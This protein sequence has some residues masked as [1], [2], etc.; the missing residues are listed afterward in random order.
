MAACS[1]SEVTR[2]GNC[3]DRNAQ[4]EYVALMTSPPFCKD[5]IQEPCCR[6]ETAR[7]AV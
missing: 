1:R 7:E 6:Q 3:E 5:D 2:H 4:S